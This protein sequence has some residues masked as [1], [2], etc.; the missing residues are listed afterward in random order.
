VNFALI[1]F[2]AVSRYTLI[3]CPAASGLR[4][5]E[6]A[7]GSGLR[8]RAVVADDGNEMLEI[9]R[10]LGGISRIYCDLPSNGPYFAGLAACLFILSLA[11]QA[12]QARVAGSVSLLSFAVMMSVL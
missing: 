11:P 4:V 2:Y 3:R 9:A 7:N 5:P 1:T 12:I 8:F 6:W 10:T